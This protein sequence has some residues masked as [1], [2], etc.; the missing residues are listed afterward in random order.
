MGGVEEFVEGQ[1]GE[2][3]EVCA[4]EDRPHAFGRV[5]IGCIRGQVLHTH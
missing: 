1:G 3:G 5:E 4:F 2:V